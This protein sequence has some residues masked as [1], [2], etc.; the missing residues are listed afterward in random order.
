MH[1]RAEATFNTWFVEH[2]TTGTVDDWILLLRAG[3]R[4][5]VAATMNTTQQLPQ[6]FFIDLGPFVAL[7]PFKTKALAVPAIADSWE[8]CIENRL[9]EISMGQTLLATLVN[10]CILTLD[11]KPLPPDYSVV[12]LADATIRIRGPAMRGGMQGATADAAFDENFQRVSITRAINMAPTEG[13]MEVNARTWRH[14]A[15]PVAATEA[16]SSQTL[17]G[18]PSQFVI[19]RP[20][21]FQQLRTATSGAAIDLTSEDAFNRQA[22]EGCTTGGAVKRKLSQAEKDQRRK[23]TVKRKLSHKTYKNTEKW[24]VTEIDLSIYRHIPD[25]IC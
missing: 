13:Q 14:L 22:D 9:M 24:K 8:T 10:S 25:S 4:T 7:S 3:A 15:R 21:T 6:P 18:Q 23:N 5:K 1:A 12:D 19:R 16:S 2:G 20:V 17:S 11:G